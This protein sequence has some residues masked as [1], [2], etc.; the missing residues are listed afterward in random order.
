MEPVQPYV[1]RNCGTHC[2][3]TRIQVVTMI[4]PIASGPVGVEGGS[5]RVQEGRGPHAQVPL[6]F[7]IDRNT[8]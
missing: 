2:H 8:R 7:A 1:A 5:L 6:K 4:F 3:E